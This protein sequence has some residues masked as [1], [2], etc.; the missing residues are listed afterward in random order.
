MI[1]ATDTKMVALVGVT[2]LLWLL[3]VL[4]IVAIASLYPSHQAL[5]IGFGVGGLAFILPL[6]ILGFVWPIPNADTPSLA[7]CDGL[8]SPSVSIQRGLARATRFLREVGACID[9]GRKLMEAVN[10]IQES[11]GALQHDVMPFVSIGAD[12]LEKIGL[13]QWIGRV[14]R[15]SVLRCDSRPPCVLESRLSVGGSGGSS[16]GSGGS[17]GGS[18][19][20]SCGDGR[21]ASS[22]AAS[23]LYVIESARD[24]LQTLCRSTILIINTVHLPADAVVA[25]AQQGLDWLRNHPSASIE[26][27]RAKK[28]QFLCQ[29]LVSAIGLVKLPIDLGQHTLATTATQ[30]LDWL[31]DNRSASIEQLK[32]KQQSLGT[33]CMSVLIR[34]IMNLLP[35]LPKFMTIKLSA[36][37]NPPSIP[38][39]TPTTITNSTPPTASIANETLTPASSIPTG[40]APSRVDPACSTDEKHP[41][42]DTMTRQ[43]PLELERSTI[44]VYCYACRMKFNVADGPCNVVAQNTVTEC[45]DW[46]DKN[47][48][49]SLELLVAKRKMLESICMPLFRD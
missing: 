45:L 18:G 34:I 13:G 28:L 20:S 41:T 8:M 46:M 6:V 9:D 29:F 23:A 37:P 21:T 17:S 11:A 38:N 1:T 43:S 19:G 10:D 48:T 42:P 47:P 36:S 26:Q 39:T 2:L 3:G 15:C 14:P 35:Q 40:E 7:R 30:C 12:L 33:A 27:L 5:I 25:V 31:N 24:D 49:A 22:H 44:M 16:S 4:P 32:T